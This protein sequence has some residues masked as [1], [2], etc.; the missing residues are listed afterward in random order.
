MRDFLS[1]IM[2]IAERI[3]QIIDHE[4]LTVASFARKIGVGDQTVRS[5]CVLKRN[6][7]G[8]EF[9]SSLIQTFEWL[10]PVWVLTGKGDMVIQKRDNEKC[11]VQSLGELVKYLREKDEKIERLIEEKTTWRLKYEMTASN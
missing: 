11:E 8:F 6:K 10:N 2:D 1:I 4:G 3:N 5:V 9:L 7:P